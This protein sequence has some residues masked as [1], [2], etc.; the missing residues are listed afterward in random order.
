M[1]K[2]T[3]EPES[4]L[5]Q[6]KEVF[7]THVREASS[8]KKALKVLQAAFRAQRRRMLAAKR[9]QKALQRTLRSAQQNLEQCR[10]WEWSTVGAKLRLAAV[11]ARMVVAHKF[12]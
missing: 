2:T 9:C 6:S 5:R 8:Q 12:R 11:R 3:V 4:A 10:R 7:R 1:G